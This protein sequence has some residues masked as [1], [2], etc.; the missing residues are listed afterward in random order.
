MPETVTA[1]ETMIRMVPESPGALR[2]VDLFRKR[3][4]GAESNFAVGLSR[5]GHSV[6]WI[7]KLGADEFGQ[8]I[9]TL[10]R[11]EGV[12]VSQVKFSEELPTG[13]CFNEFR[14]QGRASNLY[15]RGNS[16]ASSLSPHDI[17][18]EY[19]AKAKLLHLTGVTP[20]LSESCREMVFFAIDQARK[21]N[22]VISFDP[23]IRF[24]LWGADTARQTL[25]E[26]IRRVDLLLLTEEE[27]RL[28]LT[29][30]GC[31]E[32]AAAFH[33]MSPDLVVIRREDGV[34][35]SDSSSAEWV[36]GFKVDRVVDPLGAGDAFDAA[37][38][39][40]WLEGKDLQQS[41][42]YGNA[43]GAITVSNP[44]NIE[45]FPTRSEIADFLGRESSP[46]R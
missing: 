43:A 4:G 5:M 42:R 12:D 38:V 22:V 10:L 44:G 32:Q 21:R 1:G 18:P 8:Q 24:K 37:F 11:G 16:A 28:L 23:N 17:D 39:A 33:E 29:V 31:R 35:V 14:G 20:A 6:G 2:F 40:G 41:A 15:Y 46:L 9:V 34:F 27:A 30:E 25:L 13:V 3:T 36:P 26:I 7:S 45:A 19:L